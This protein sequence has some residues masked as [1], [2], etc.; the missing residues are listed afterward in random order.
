MVNVELCED[1]EGEVSDQMIFSYFAKIYYVICQLVRAQGNV[2]FESSRLLGGAQQQKHVVWIP[3]GM[4]ALSRG[5]K[6]PEQRPKFAVVMAQIL[7][8]TWGS[9]RGSVERLPCMSA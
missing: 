6:D 8:Q 1:S 5:V 4:E 9:K 7:A 3:F 2:L